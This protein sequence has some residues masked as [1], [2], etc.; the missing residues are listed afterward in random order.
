LTHATTAAGQHG[1][2]IL[3]SPPLL[4]PRLPSA[5]TALSPRYW[6]PTPLNSKER[7]RVYNEI[8]PGPLDGRSVTIVGATPTASYKGR[9]LLNTTSTDMAAADSADPVAIIAGASITPAAAVALSARSNGKPRQ[10]VDRNNKCSTIWPLVIPNRAGSSA[11]CYHAAA[12]EQYRESVITVWFDQHDN[13]SGNKFTRKQFNDALA[14][15]AGKQL[16]ATL[17]YLAPANGVGI[18]TATYQRTH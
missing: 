13:A 5:S 3:T 1:R 17:T 15:L 10:P 7:K 11:F 16:T 14:A 6:W 9:R 2:I 12:V 18:T 4:V 8:L